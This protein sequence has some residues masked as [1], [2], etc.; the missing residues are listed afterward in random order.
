MPDGFEVDPFEVRHLTPAQWAALR[1]DIIRRAH[2]ERSRVLRGVAAGAVAAARRTLNA[3]GE[4]RN[5][6]VFAL[7]RHL[8][9]RKRLNELRQLSAMDDNELKDIGISRTEIRSAMWSTA[10]LLRRSR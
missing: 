10:R 9:R 8:A 7:R 2:D 1:H 5:L 6:V 4:L 3:A